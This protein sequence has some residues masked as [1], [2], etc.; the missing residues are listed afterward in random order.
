MLGY[1]VSTVRSENT[2]KMEIR[3][4]MS[5]EF[6]WKHKPTG[7]VYIRGHSESVKDII[8]TDI[9][10]NCTPFCPNAEN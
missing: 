4:Y 9:I 6:G 2:W 3:Q 8:I 1:L 10:S 5:P 7:D